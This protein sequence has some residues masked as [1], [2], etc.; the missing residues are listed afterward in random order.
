MEKLREDILRS[1]IDSMV[2]NNLVDCWNEQTSETSES[3]TIQV[4][5]GNDEDYAYSSDG[6]RYNRNAVFA[7]LSE[8][9]YQINQ[10]NVD[11]AAKIL[12]EQG[13]QV[14]IPGS[15]TY[16][17]VRHNTLEN[18][19]ENE[20]M[21]YINFKIMEEINKLRRELLN[22]SVVEYAVEVITDNASG[23]TNIQRLK[24]ILRDYSAAGWKLKNLFTNELGV[25]SV[26]VGGFGTNATID[27]V[28]LIFERPKI[29]SDDMKDII[30]K[31]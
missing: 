12:S 13:G 17:V 16:S 2:K 6:T 31:K 22:H 8:K 10:T 14:V 26:S 30:R 9:G 11:A 15:T 27:Q 1:V 3:V 21:Q 20:I 24:N 23:G 5:S 7:Y 18:S 28:V 25:N 29:I 4:D 19:D